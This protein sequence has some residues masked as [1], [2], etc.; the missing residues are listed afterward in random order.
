MFLLLKCQ[1]EMEG[2]TLI[3][4]DRNVKN[5]TFLEEKLGSYYQ[6]SF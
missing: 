3:T 5:P 4:I 2:G 1:R 6:K